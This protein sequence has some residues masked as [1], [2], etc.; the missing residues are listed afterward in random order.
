MSTPD[1]II[2]DVHRMV[3]ATS[4]RGIHAYKLH[5]E[6]WLDGD[7]DDDEY[8]IDPKYTLNVD[9]RGDKVG[10]RVRFLTEITTPIGEIACGVLAEYE[11]PE[12]VLRQESGDALAEFVNGV[13]LMHILPY[14]R[15]GIA[16]LT[17]RTFDAPLLMPIIQRGEMSFAMGID[18]VLDQ[19]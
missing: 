11:H 6:R 12:V 4:L 16:D 7:S 19:D 2:V 13:A 3:E 5:A 10:F 8:E 18:S 15:Q 9:I 14:A 1:E 17:Q